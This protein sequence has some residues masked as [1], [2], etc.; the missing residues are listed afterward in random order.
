MEAGFLS[1][2]PGLLFLV[3]RTVLVFFH[4]YNLSLLKKR[5]KVWSGH[6]PAEGFARVPARKGGGAW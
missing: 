6:T 1:V 2:K 3:N 5:L 4:P